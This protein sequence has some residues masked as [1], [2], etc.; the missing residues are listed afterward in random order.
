[1][2]LKTRWEEEF[3]VGRMLALHNPIIQTRG[4]EDFGRVLVFKINVFEMTTNTRLSMRCLEIYP[5]MLGSSY[6]VH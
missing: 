2:L 1:M 4:A 6:I 3:V 5:H